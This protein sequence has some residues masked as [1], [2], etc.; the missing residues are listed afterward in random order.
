MS[1]L[2]ATCA[3]KGRKRE[4]FDNI[5]KKDEDDKYIDLCFNYKGVL[6]NYSGKTYFEIADDELSIIQDYIADVLLEY[7]DEELE[8]LEKMINNKE[9]NIIE[10]LLQ[11]PIKKMEI[12]LNYDV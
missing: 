5:F 11:Q 12:P 2:R 10:F 4:L 1:L 6:K 7:N 3:L 8:Q 9:V